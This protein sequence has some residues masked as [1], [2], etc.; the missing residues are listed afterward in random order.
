MVPTP[1]SVLS[2]NPGIRMDYPGCMYV[3]SRAAVQIYIVRHA[4]R[5]YIK[6]ALL[7]LILHT[8]IL[9]SPFGFPDSRT[10]GFERRRVLWYPGCMYVVSRAAVQIYIV[11]H[12]P[13]AY[14]VNP[15]CT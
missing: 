10:S 12:A 2:G 5:A 13:R 15:V 11:R 7:P 9:G 3:V 6:S 1:S 14:I 4:P 8:C